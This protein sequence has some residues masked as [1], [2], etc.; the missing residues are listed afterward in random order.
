MVATACLRHDTVNKAISE[1]LVDRRERADCCSGRQVFIDRIARQKDVRGSFVSVDHK[2]IE[3]LLERCSLRVCRPNS[4]RV[5]RFGFE[6]Q[7]AVDSKVWSIDGKRCVVGTTE[8]VDQ[9]VGMIIQKVFV[10]GHERTDDASGSIVF[11]NARW[12]QCDVAWRIVLV[13]HVDH[14]GSFDRQS[15]GIS[16]S[17]TNRQSRLGFEIQGC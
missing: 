11:R 17:N 14:Q 13:D 4:N 1:I 15:S 16:G 2:N 6:I 12:G 5:I 3:H 9:G 10:A 7:R 8:T